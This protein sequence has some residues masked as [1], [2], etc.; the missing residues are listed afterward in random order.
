MLPRTEVVSGA[1]VTFSLFMGYIFLCQYFFSHQ[2]LILNLVY[3]LCVIIFLYFSIT[4]YKYLTESAQ[5]KFIKNA[6]V[7]YLAPSVVEELIRSPEK[8]QL[9]GEERVITAFFS[10]VQGFTS[11]S[12]KLSPKELVDLLNEFLTEMTNIILHHK[13]TVDKFE[14][15]DY[16]GFS[17]RPMSLTIRPL[18][19]RKSMC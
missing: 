18:E 14:G 7:T 11:I 8:L 15:D 12:E 3:P 19:L 16:T 2:R 1:A 10:D 13:V 6:F 5:K 4:I 9:G 17:G